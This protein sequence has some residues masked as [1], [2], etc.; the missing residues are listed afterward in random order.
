[1]MMMKDE[2]GTRR[3]YVDRTAFLSLAIATFHLFS[4]TVPTTIS[5]TTVLS[6]VNAVEGSIYTDIQ[7]LGK[8]SQESQPTT[9]ANST[10]PTEED[11][12]LKENNE[13]VSFGS[14]EVGVWFYS[15]KFARL[16]NWI[17]DDLLQRN[18]NTIYFSEVGDGD[19]WDDPAKASQYTSF[20]NYAR[21]NGMKVFGV[22]LEDP[23]YVLMN[24]RGLN[25]A[26]GDFIN[27]TKYMFDTY[28]IDVEVHSINTIYPKGEYLAYT[29]NEKF[30][31]EKYIQM[32]KILRN[33]A[34]EHGVRY[35]DTIPPSYH[36]QIIADGIATDG[37]NQLSSHSINVMAYE[38]T[39]EKTMT[40]ISQILADS[41]IRLVININIA[42]ESSEPYLE[43]Q[44]IPQAIKSLKEQSLPI[45]IWYADH[46]LLNPDPALNLDPTLFGLSPR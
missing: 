20:I 8:I 11:G 24:E 25:A 4:C 38:N 26:F 32:S 5:T 42:Q 15:S 27:K 37:V 12:T 36:T 41:K 33:I 30:Y 44:E 18:I 10:L 22:A 16:Q 9:T 14:N 29:G 45:G 28:V 31:L 21:A 1:M 13:T 39:V 34:D 43:G 19:G 46:Y 3:H 2:K 7:S 17:I 6:N 35:I 40:S 23:T